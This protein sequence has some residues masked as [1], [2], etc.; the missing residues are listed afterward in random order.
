MTGE[1]QE[2]GGGGVGTRWVARGRQRLPRTV[3]V[4]VKGDCAVEAHA[5]FKAHHRV[6]QDGQAVV[7]DK[8]SGEE[9]ALRREPRER[10]RAASLCV[11]TCDSAARS[12]WMACA[13]K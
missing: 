13:I 9:A 7:L 2:W 4:V 6:V 11:P 12:I 10:Q 1:G 5:N 8:G 3:Q